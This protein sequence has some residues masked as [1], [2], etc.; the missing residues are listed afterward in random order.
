MPKTTKPKAAAP[1][2]P[3]ATYQGKRMCKGHASSAA[4]D[5]RTGNK[6]AA[7]YMSQYRKHLRSQREK[8]SQQTASPQ[9]QQ[10]STTSTF[11]F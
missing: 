8:A 6:E 5:M 7:Q 2:P 1:A 11:F 9:P 10:S 3:A 4:K